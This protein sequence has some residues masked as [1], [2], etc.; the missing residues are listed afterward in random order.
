MNFIEAM[1]KAEQ[2]NNERTPGE[3]G[4]VFYYVDSSPRVIG[5]WVIKEL[6]EE[7]E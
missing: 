1:Y 2:M 5:Q 3:L 4:E 6:T 7:E